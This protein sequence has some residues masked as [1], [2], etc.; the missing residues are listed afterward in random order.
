MANLK[1]K[2]RP[3]KTGYG[4][5]AGRDCIY[6]DD[7][8]FLGG[9]YRLRLSGEIN[10]SLVSEPPESSEGFIPYELIFSGVLALKV[11]ELDSWDFECESSFDEILDSEWVASL[12]GKVTSANKHI[13]I[14]TYD[15]V[16]EV[17]CSSYKFNY[18]SK[19][20]DAA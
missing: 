11:I 20:Q 10:K 16:F 19:A 1:R 8:S 15:D 9:T 14:Q 12:G 3:I 7:V 18:L 6:L 5:L 17:V 13:F 4:F 2:Y